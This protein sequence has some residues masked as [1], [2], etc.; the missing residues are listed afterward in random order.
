MKRRASNYPYSNL[1]ELTEFSQKWPAPP[2]EQECLA[3]WDKYGM[4]PNIRQHSRMVAHIAKT[5]ALY[6]KEKGIE[7]DEAACNAAGLL[8][9]LAKTY[10][11]EYGGSHALL[12]GAWVAQETGNFAISQGV[13]LHVHWPWLFPKGKKICCLPIF[14]IYADK[15]VKH[16]QCV[17]LNERFDDVLVRYGKG[18]AA[19][20]GIEKSFHKTLLMEKL[21]SEQL[22]RNLHE[23]SFNCGRMVN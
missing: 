7:V 3:L 23:D 15:R 6:S 1:P 17:T 10:C 19:R 14:V 20:R 21:L 5:L 13:L 22:G 9:D 4:W 11:L 18:A 2:D 12:G 16:D 8:H